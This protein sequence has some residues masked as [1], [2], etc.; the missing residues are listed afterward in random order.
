MYTLVAVVPLKPDGEELI[1]NGGVAET[2]MFMVSWPA[3]LRQLKLERVLTVKVHCAFTCV[4]KTNNNTSRHIF[5]STLKG[6]LLP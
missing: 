3:E 2:G 5:L 4:T 1:V 6:Y